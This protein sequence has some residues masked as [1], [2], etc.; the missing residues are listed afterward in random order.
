MV[1]VLQANLGAL[2]VRLRTLGFDSLE[3]VIAAAAVAGPELTKVLGQPIDQVLAP[4]V[5]MAQLV[6]AALRDALD[7]LPCALGALFD[8]YAAAPVLPAALA[9]AAPPAAATLNLAAQMPP[10]RD[11]GQRGTCVAFASLAAYEQ[12]LTLNHAYRD[13]SPQFLYCDCKANDGAPNQTGTW[14]RIA[15]AMLQRDGCCEEADWPYVP[16]PIPGNEGQGPFPP[17]T[18]VR[19][20]SFRISGYNQ[21][22][23]TSVQDIKNSLAADRVV[24]FSI[25]VYNSW[26]RST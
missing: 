5:A 4:S 15:M 23:P 24:A 21:L 26:Y 16:T 7:A 11:Q 14:I 9:F 19:A 22:P 3:H 20:L 2:G 18:Q 13:M 6:P 10:V 12:Y 17:L 8:S 25:P 1:D